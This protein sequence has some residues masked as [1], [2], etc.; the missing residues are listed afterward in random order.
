M[1][2]YRIKN[3]Y[4]KTSQILIFLNIFLEESYSYSFSC[5]A[6]MLFVRP[7][8]GRNHNP[9]LCLHVDIF[10]NNCVIPRMAFLFL[11]DRIERK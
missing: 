11:Y 1:Q 5:F 10:F 7:R 4:T 8:E 2:L 6:S 9:F 3:H